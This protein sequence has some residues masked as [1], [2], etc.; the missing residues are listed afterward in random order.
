MNIPQ[1]VA[2]DFLMKF[3]R[4]SGFKLKQ[5]EDFTEEHIGG[6]DIW[7]KHGRRGSYKGL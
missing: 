3:G 2:H 1:E 5:R 6:L 4:K 7:D